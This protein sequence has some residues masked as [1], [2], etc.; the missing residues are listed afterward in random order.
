MKFASFAALSIATLAPTA[1]AQTT[2]TLAEKWAISEEPTLT[3]NS[4]DFT[5]TFTVT[6]FIVPGQAKHEIYTE[7]CRDEGDLVPA[8][9]GINNG[10]LT[11]TNNTVSNTGVVNLNKQITL[12][13]SVDPTTI[14]DNADLYSEDTTTGAVMARVR[15]CVRFFLNTP[16]NAAIEV[17]FLETII[18]LDVDLSDGFEIAAVAV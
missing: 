5:L 9:V 12:K 6:D 13:M 18:T 10:G 11:D 16:G 1:L 17:N 7:G 15:F 8:G 14:T 2:S 4:L 3:Y